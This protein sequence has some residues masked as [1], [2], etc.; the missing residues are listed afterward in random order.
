MNDNPRITKSVLSYLSSACYLAGAFVPIVGAGGAILEIANITLALLSET[1]YISTGHNSTIILRAIE[2][3]LKKAAQEIAKT[4]KIEISKKTR[5]RLIKELRESISLD[6]INLEIFSN[7]MISELKTES[8]F[9]EDAKYATEFFNALISD[10]TIQ[11]YLIIPNIYKKV[12]E[13]VLKTD[14]HDAR[15]SIIEEKL[16]RYVQGGKA[17]PPI[18]IS[19]ETQRNKSTFRGRASL[20]DQV[21]DRIAKRDLTLLVGEPGIGKTDISKA[22][23]HYFAG[24]YSRSNIRYIGWFTYSESLEVTLRDQ[25]VIENHFKFYNFSETLSYIKSLGP[26]LLI[27]LDNVDKSIVEDPDLIKIQQ[28]NCSVVIT[29]RSPNVIDEQ[30]IDVPHLELSDSRELFYSFYS[31][32]RNDPV[33]DSILENINLNTL[34]IELIAKYAQ[35]KTQ[36]LQSLASYFSHSAEGVANLDDSKKVLHDSSYQ[37]VRKHI[38]DL[39]ELEG[40]NKR[41]SSTLKRFSLLPYRS[42]PVK[43]LLEWNISSDIETLEYLHYK[44][45]LEH[46]VNGARMHSIISEAILGNSEN[47]YSIFAKM[48]APMSN[49]IELKPNE[50]FIDVVS[51]SIIIWSVVKRCSFNSLDYSHLLNNLAIVLKRAD[52]QTDGEK[53]MEQSYEIKKRKGAD[54]E[55]LAT[56]LNNLSLFKKDPQE[57]ISYAKQAVVL[58]SKI[59]EEGSLEEIEQFCTSLNNLGVAYNYAKEYDLAE[60][61]FLLC[62]KEQTYHFGSSYIGVGQCYNN[63][64]HT[65]KGKGELLRATLKSFIATNYYNAPDHAIYLYVH[66]RCSQELGLFDRALRFHK[67]AYAKFSKHPEANLFKMEK[68]QAQIIICLEK[69]DQSKEL[70][71]AVLLMESL[72][73]QKQSRSFNSLV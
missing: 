59:A 24:A 31:V 2:K 49:S 42:V 41:I 6:A 12:E 15:I 71:E 63:L 17:G 67:L 25:I 58:G 45:W 51:D 50:S 32:E 36:K 53:L 29:S 4:E 39:L 14:G 48:F 64:A 16:A 43:K 62:I 20:F 66:A 69:L 46:T 34:L 37:A 33:L 72:S 9:Q 26:E 40:F 61:I 54:R 38:S 3:N 10:D 5:T 19:L 7:E 47:Y 70:K 22:L 56:A 57:K 55:S 8:P 13:T 1:G 68:V 27:F 28:L 65:C 73:T 52:F 18:I 21:V 23:F 35:S 11:R 30:A 44:G 60:K